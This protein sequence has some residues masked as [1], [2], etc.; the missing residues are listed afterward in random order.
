M[1]I[2]GNLEDMNLPSIVTLNC[3]DGKQACLRINY[4]G[5]EAAVFFENGQV[6]HAILDSD[7]GEEVVYELLTWDGGSF[8]IEQNVPPPKCTITTNWQGLL[9]EGMRR[10]D[11]GAANGD[12]LDTIMEFEGKEVRTMAKKGTVAARLEE[13]AKEIPGFVAAAV[14]GKDGLSIGEYVISD[15]DIETAG[16]QFALVMQLVQKSAAQ[17]G[18]NQIE[19]NLVTS[20]D[21]Y[22]ISRY[23][24]DGSYFLVTAVDKAGSSL[25]NVR[26]VTRLFG[27]GLWS[28]IPK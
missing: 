12:G 22:I 25:G 28:D 21:R 4:S 27:E 11:E 10:I 15:F 16:S 3:N 6:V 23:L 7:E 19:D 1:T 5:R 20:K 14:V 2:K 26:L 17:L 24:G 8:E 13:M 18:S 9:L